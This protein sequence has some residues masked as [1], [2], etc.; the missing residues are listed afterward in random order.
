MARAP[1]GTTFAPFVRS[2]FLIES[3]KGPKLSTLLR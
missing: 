3:S 1:S 2:L